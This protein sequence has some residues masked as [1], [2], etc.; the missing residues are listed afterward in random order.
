MSQISKGQTTNQS[1]DRWA[2][3]IE[4]LIDK[5]VGKNMSMTYDFQKLTIGGLG[6]LKD[7]AVRT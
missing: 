7:Q 1:P 2:E 6:Q 5:L 4:Q 3:I